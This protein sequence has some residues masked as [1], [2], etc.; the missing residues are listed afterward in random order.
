MPEE[1]A[2]AVTAE[3]EAPT[4]FDTEG[5]FTENWTHLLTDTA[6]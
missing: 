1:P 2:V 3:P 5:N 4:M 6:L